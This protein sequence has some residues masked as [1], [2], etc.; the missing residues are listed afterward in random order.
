MNVLALLGFG[1]SSE[2]SSARDRLRTALA[3]RDHAQAEL[4]NAH[5]AVARVEDVIASAR[6]SDRTAAQANVAAAEA[7]KAWSAAGA[8]PDAAGE[9]ERLSAAAADAERAAEQASFLAAGAR[10]GLGK[11][12]DAQSYSASVLNDARREVQESVGMILA[13][14]IAPQLEALERAAR[15]FEAARLEVMGLYRLLDPMRPGWR[16]DGT[17]EARE[18]A[19]IIEAALVRSQ[20]RELPERTMRNGFHVPSTHTPAAVLEGTAA[21]R[22]R[23]RRLREDP[24]VQF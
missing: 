12:R 16:D 10:A 19:K 22:E 9:H 11:I 4:D 21:W 15:D 6:S 13:G 23:A 7:A 5:A 18:A 20:I 8:D 1:R 3:N 14:E 24:D 17:H 2:P